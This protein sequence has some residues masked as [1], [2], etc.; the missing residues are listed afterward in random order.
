MRREI[1]SV[2]GALALVTATSLLS[3]HCSRNQPRIALKDTEGR[4]FTLTC[5]QPDKCEITSSQVP[6]PSSTAPDGARPG[7]VLH[8]ASRLYAVCDVWLQGTGSSSTNPGDCRALVCTTDADCP[9]AQGMSHGSCTNQ[10]CIEPTGA[11][12]SE[13]AVLLCLSGTGPPSASNTKQVE[14][15]ALG[16]NCGTPCRVPVVCRQP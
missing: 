7:F 2:R 9:P 6:T 11:I 3:I 10:L 1:L 4:T 15:F 14:R 5:S 12:A 8:Q 16:S 13:D